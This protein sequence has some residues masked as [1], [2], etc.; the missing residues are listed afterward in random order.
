MAPPAAKTPFLVAIDFWE[1]GLAF[2]ELD[3]VTDEVPLLL[4][5]W[6][7]D[8]GELEEDELEE[9]ELEEDE[10]EEDEP[11]DVEFDDDE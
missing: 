7:L 9:D 5:C 1:V 10:M 8:E 2:G 11:E 4:F 6:V 3:G